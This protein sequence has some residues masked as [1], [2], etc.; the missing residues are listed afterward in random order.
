MERLD[1]FV[2]KNMILLVL[3]FLVLGLLTGRYVNPGTLKI[4]KRFIIPS[5]FLMLWAMMINMDLSKF[6]N[7]LRYP[8]ELLIGSIM[9][10]VVA[11]LI[12]YPIALV[13]TKDPNIFA[14][15]MLA[16]LVP[17]GGF[18]TYWSGI[19]GASLPLAVAIQ[20]VTFVIAII[21]VPYGMK[22]AIG[23]KINMNIFVLIRSILILVVGPFL[24]AVGT[25]EILLRK[26][27]KT[28]LKRI[29]P[30]LHFISSLMAFYLVFAGTSLKALFI[31]KH[32]GLII[33]PIIGA[34]FYYLFMF[35][36]SYFV[37]KRIFKLSFEESIPVVYGASTKNLSIAMGLAISTFGP[38]A[39]MGVVSALIIQMPM[40]SIWYKVFER[41]SKKRETLGTAIV[42]EAEEM[43]KET[44]SKL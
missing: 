28:G 13:I 2:K 1:K 43:E 22:F 10:L 5:A 44:V 25:R 40:A 23:D 33:L 30:S 6:V 29:T 19:L 17:P 36:L 39:L 31:F 14:G 38:L 9:S 26:T 11:P 37:S 32:P 34:F 16:G 7:A 41:I 15:L 4:L 8:R 42:E 21:W 12:M 20:L 3:L 18:I 35:P 27:G 24:L